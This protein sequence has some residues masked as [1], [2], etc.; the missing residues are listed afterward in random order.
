[1]TSTPSDESNKEQNFN[2]SGYVE[3]N[4]QKINHSGFNE[5]RLGEKRLLPYENDDRNKHSEKRRFAS[6]M[7]EENTNIN[8]NVDDRT[9]IVPKGGDSKREDNYSKLISDD[10]RSSRSSER[11]RNADLVMFFIRI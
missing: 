9:D 8:S 6:P 11:D 5:A 1:M 2:C 4:R 10:R 3:K 7:I